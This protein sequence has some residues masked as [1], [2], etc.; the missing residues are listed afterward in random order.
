MNTDQNHRTRLLVRLV[1]SVVAVGILWRLSWGGGASFLPPWI[2]RHGPLGWA[3]PPVVALI[4]ALL[5]LAATRDAWA[6]FVAT[7][8]LRPPQPWARWLDPDGV[9]PDHHFHIRLIDWGIGLSLVGVQFAVLDLYRDFYNPEN[10]TVGHDNY[11]FLSTAV[12]AASGRW[13]LYTVDK[14][15]LYGEI[16]SWISVFFGGDVPR[17]AIAVNMACMS[18]TQLPTYLL[19]RLWGGRV[20]GLVAGIML[21]GT[22]LFYPYAHETSS[23]PMYFLVAT[24]VVLAISWALV[25]PRPRTFL[26]A[27]VWMG[28]L[29]L[30]QVKN[31]TINIPMAGLLVMAI[32]LDGHGARLRRGLAALTPVAMALAILFTYPVDFTPLNVLVMHH[33]EEVHN[34]IPYQWPETLTPAQETPSPLSPYLPGF[35]RGGDFEG[36]TGVMATPPNS[37]VMIAFRQTDGTFNWA[38]APRTSIPP[39]GVRLEHNLAQAAGLIPGVAPIMLALA[40][41]GFIWTLF[42]PASSVGRRWLVPVGWWRAGVLLIPLLSCMGSLSLKFNLRYIFHAAPTLFVLTGVAAAGLSRILLRRGG[43]VWR[44]PAGVATIGLG[45]SLALALFLRTSM[46]PSGLDAATMNAAFF[47]LPVDERQLMGKGYGLVSRYLEEYVDENSPIYDCT[48]VA[49]G[50][51]RPNDPRLVR[52]AHAERDRLCKK[53][54]G[55]PKSETQRIMVLTSI[56]EFFGPDVVTPGQA[57]RAGWT[58]LYGYTMIGP[59]EMGLAPGPQ[60]QGHGEIAVFTDAPQEHQLGRSML[61]GASPS[62][63]AVLRKSSGPGSRRDPP[64]PGPQ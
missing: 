7:S 62:T 6:L 16:T 26:I 4:L 35:L 52:P 25:R 29:T 50:L 60:L 49:M 44:A 53:Q 20:A 8:R 43:A 12:A 3:W 56:P 37:D 58:L 57:A 24:S 30:T 61:D 5:V 19:G 17:A 23:Y 36:L 31:F 34:E 32:F 63:S 22:A 1:V 42:L 10:F 38:V 48:P 13:D 2:H 39:L 64:N 45:L 41:L 51:Y 15:P 33:R 14:R 9:L 21:L 46:F 18:L 40:G 27:G 28:L 54:L 11:A 55:I 47:R 59:R